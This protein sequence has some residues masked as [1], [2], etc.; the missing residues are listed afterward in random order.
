SC[1]GATDWDHAR[2]KEYKEREA[3]WLFGE[4]GWLDSKGIFAKVSLEVIRTGA[5]RDG[6]R[7]PGPAS[8]RPEPV[9]L[10]Y[11]FSDNDEPLREALERHLASLKWQGILADWHHRKIG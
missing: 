7:A 8:S 11:C 10:F 3:V 4:G 1:F 2:I 9:K 5:E 6:E